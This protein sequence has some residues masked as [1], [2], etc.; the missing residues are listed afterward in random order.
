MKKKILLAIAVFLFQFYLSSQLLAATVIKVKGKKVLLSMKKGE[1]STGDTYSLINAN[2]QVKGKVRIVKL[3]GNKALAEV[4]NGRAVINYHTKVDDSFSDFSSDFAD[5][6]VDKKLLDI[7]ALRAYL[8]LVMGSNLD[9]NPFVFGGDYIHPFLPKI[10][11]K[12]GMLYWSHSESGAEVSLLD[13]SGGAYYFHK[14]NP[15]LIFEGGARIGMSMYSALLRVSNG[16]GG[17][18]TSKDSKSY[19]T[20][21]PFAAVT[22]QINNKMS[23]GGEWRYPIFLSD[24]EFDGYYLMGTFNYSL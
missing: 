5:E 4:V 24:V 15:Q 21:S 8:G 23:A 9:A 7:K 14:M 18:S 17:Y 19:L 6:G 2:N 22:Y 3:K 11:L 13:I 12:G 20:L 1:L 10:N 16:F